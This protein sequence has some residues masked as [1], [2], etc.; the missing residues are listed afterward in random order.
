MKETIEDK[1]MVYLMVW[2][3]MTSSLLGMSI[4]IVQ[5]VWMIT[6]TVIHR[7]SLKNTIKYLC[8]VSYNKE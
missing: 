1:L 6:S 8:N 4:V 3:Q 5:T 7:C 2:Q